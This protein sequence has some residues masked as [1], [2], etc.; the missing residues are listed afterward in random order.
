MGCHTWFYIPHPS[1]PKDEECIKYVKK[2][3]LK[4]RFP[5]KKY[6]SG[7]K[8]SP[9]DLD[10]MKNA[11]NLDIEEMRYRLKIFQRQLRM[12]DKGLCKEA[13]R[14]RYTDCY[15]GRYS[16]EVGKDLG[17]MKYY[18]EKFYISY[19]PGTLSMVAGNIFRTFNYP[20][21]IL[22]CYEDFERFY[23]THSCIPADDNEVKR[24]MEQFWKEW[25]G[26]IVTFG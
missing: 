25:P 13:V 8:L 26:G 4:T 14:K 3:I 11:Y 2:S 18:K 12:I 16:N 19:R 24:K 15:P 23:T 9:E 6:I 21:D 22:E 7:L 1:P 10:W 17:P 5:I 20:S